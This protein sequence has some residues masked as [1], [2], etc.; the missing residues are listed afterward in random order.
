MA[1]DREKSRDGIRRAV[2]L[3]KGQKSLAAKINQHLPDD[4]KPISQPYISGWLLRDMSTKVPPAEYVLP[5]VR[6]VNYHLNPSDLR[7]DIYPP[8]LCNELRDDAA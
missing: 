6:A 7:P 2:E 4:V 3:A 5:I 8:N 1:Y